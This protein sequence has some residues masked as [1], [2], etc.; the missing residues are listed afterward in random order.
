MKCYHTGQKKRLVRYAASNIRGCT[1]NQRSDSLP[2]AKLITAMMRTPIQAGRPYDLR[3]TPNPQPMQ[4]QGKWRVLRVYIRRQSASRRHQATL[5]MVPPK[6][7][8]PQC[9]KTLGASPP[10][11]HRESRATC[12]ASAFGVTCKHRVLRQT[13]TLSSDPIR[14]FVKLGQPLTYHFRVIK[15]A[16]L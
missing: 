14:P 12:T 8:P 16:L 7:T 2:S 6:R 13:T 10:G 5:L 3:P 15:L 4:R 9:F 11:F 1:G